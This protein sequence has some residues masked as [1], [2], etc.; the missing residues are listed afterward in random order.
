MKKISLTGDRPTG[1]LHIGHY[2][3]SLQ[4]RLELQ[5]KGYEQYVM[6]ADVQA[7][8]ANAH[9]PQRVRENV[10]EVALDYLAIGLDP[11]KTTICIQSYIPEIAELTM[12]FLNLVTVSRLGQ[13]PTVKTEMKEKGFVSQ[14]PAGFFMHPVHQAADILIF[15]PD[16]VP[17]GEDQLPMI[18]Q[19]N[20]IGQK[21]NTLYGKTFKKVNA[22]LSH[23]PRLPGIDGKTKMSKSLGNAILLC[24]SKKEIEKKIRA[25]YTDPK[26]I[27]VNDPGAIEGN[28]VFTYLDIFDP[29]RK[30][31]LYLKERYRKGGL[32]DVELK[33]RLT[34]ILE[35]II[36][37]IREKRE[38]Y[39]RNPKMVMRMLATGTKR[40]RQRA[41][42]TTE[43]VRSAMRIDYFKN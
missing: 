43:S 35:N 1:K 6:I 23:T 20:E 7:L 33:N 16:V 25:M 15:K 3:G 27:H 5:K 38:V 36:R 28:T 22:L 40:A 9:D 2:I 37:P 41:L 14:V 8:S 26:H 11:K 30:E 4:T 31:V 39:A 42:Q 29:N 13:N 24:D 10:Y 18:E 19:A 34:E 12:Y 32:G 17:V 21:F